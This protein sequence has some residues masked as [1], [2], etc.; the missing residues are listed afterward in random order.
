MKKRKLW[1]LLS[2]L[3]IISMLAVACGDDEKAT[4]T[5][6]P[7][8]TKAAPE[9][10][11]VP[12]RSDGLP[13]YTGGPAE[14]RMGWWGNDDRAA[15]TLKVIELFQAAYPE[16]KVAGEPNGGAGDHFQILGSLGFRVERP[17][18]GVLQS[19]E[20]AIAFKVKVKALK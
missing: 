10:T 19:S 6:K 20:S 18:M 11:E 9:P 12:A 17:Y 5:P 1:S 15:R 4:D 3:V 16:I 8:P 13:V 14:L 2:L 7:E